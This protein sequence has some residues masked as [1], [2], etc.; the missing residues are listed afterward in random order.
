MYPNLEL[1]LFKHK[2]SRKKLAQILGVSDATLRNK[3][4]GRNEF[5]FRE[6]KKILEC[7]PG[8]AWEYL[9]KEARETA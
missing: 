1:E 2:I 5:T 7:L 3:M 4:S 6:I 8:I 9:F